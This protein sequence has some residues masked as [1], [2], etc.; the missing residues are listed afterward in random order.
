MSNTS[1]Q[2]RSEADCVRKTMTCDW[3]NKWVCDAVKRS[4]CPAKIM[5]M[6]SQAVWT[7]KNTVISFNEKSNNTSRRH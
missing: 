1:S 5:A 4:K 7:T 3:T 2:S 6:N